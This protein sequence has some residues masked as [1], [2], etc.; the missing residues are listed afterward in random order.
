MSK[1]NE[2]RSVITSLWF[3]ALRWEEFCKV[4]ACVRLYLRLEDK[5]QFEHQVQFKD[6]FKE[7][8]F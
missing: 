1:R 2:V 6:G 4:L 8:I 5:K 3:K 7:H